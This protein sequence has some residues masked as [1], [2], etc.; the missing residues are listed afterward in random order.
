MFYFLIQTFCLSYFF[1]QIGWLVSDSLGGG[2]LFKPRGSTGLCLGL[3]GGNPPVVLTKTIIDLFGTLSRVIDL[4]EESNFE[5]LPPQLPNNQGNSFLVLE[6]MRL[7]LPDGLYATSATQCN[8]LNDNYQFIIGKLP[9]SPVE[10]YLLYSGLATPMQNTIENPLPDGGMAAVNAGGKMCTNAPK[11]F[12]NIESCFLQRNDACQSS[13]YGTSE[14]DWQPKI[15]KNVVICG[16][17]GEI[18][19]DGDVDASQ[20]MFSLYGHDHIQFRESL[21]LQAQTVSYTIF[22]K[23]NDQLRQ[24]MAFALSQILVIT[25]AQIGSEYRNSEIYLNYFDIF[26]R[27]AFGNYRDVLKEVSYSP[28][29]SLKVRKFNLSVIFFNH[30][31]IFDI[32][33]SRWV[34]C[35]PS[36]ILRVLATSLKLKVVSHDQTKISHAK[37]CNYFLLD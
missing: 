25:S 21:K 27:N 13:A 35:C 2:V 15:K 8:A 19:Y 6:N 9:D 23:G 4:P 36:L 17:D 31:N 29:V 3:K 7:K 10:K 32:I 34:K 18:G 1:N 24:R 28:M 16:A 5:A 12:R 20:R 22:L 26:V 37:S 30:I 11:T 33:S 14:W